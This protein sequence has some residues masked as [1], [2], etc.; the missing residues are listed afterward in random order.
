MVNPPFTYPVSQN[1]DEST[2]PEF[3]RLAAC[4]TRSWRT[5][6]QRYGSKGI[7]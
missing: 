4:A 1:S 6:C 2:P 3:Q 5:P 7:V